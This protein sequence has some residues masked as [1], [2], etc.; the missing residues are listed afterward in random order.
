MYY[1]IPITCSFLGFLTIRN[2][3]K[4]LATF[5]E[6]IDITNSLRYTHVFTPSFII[7][8]ILILLSVVIFLVDIQ[9]QNNALYLWIFYVPSFT[10]VNDIA[11]HAIM[12]EALRDQI[13]NITRSLR[14]ISEEMKIKLFHLDSNNYYSKI[15]K[16]FK[17]YWKMRFVVSKGHDLR[18]IIF[19]IY[20][21]IAAS[22]LC[23]TCYT[24]IINGLRKANGREF[25]KISLAVDYWMVCYTVDLLLLIFNC[26]KLATE[27]E[28]LTNQIFS[29]VQHHAS[30][31]EEVHIQ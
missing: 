22:I 2:R 30:Q 29:L 7:H 8:M 24:H 21:T 13:L 14:K 1:V 26:H 15:M 17:F 27:T 16:S 12:I 20:I 18:N 4:I 31:S 23:S 3:Q 11:S 25:E 10:V 28:E 9:S 5:Q 6:L 19:F